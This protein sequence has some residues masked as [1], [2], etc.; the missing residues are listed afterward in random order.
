[1]GGLALWALPAAEVWRTGSYDALFRF[2][3]RQPKGPTN[4]LAIIFLEKDPDGS[5]RRQRVELTQLLN[6]L[7]DDGCRLVVLDILLRTTNANAGVDQDLARAIRRQRG[8]VLMAEQKRV[9]WQSSSQP[10]AVAGEP[11]LACEPFLTAAGKTNWGVAWFDPDPSD[12]V[13]RRHWP[14]E[15]RPSYPSLAEAAA[16]LAGAALVDDPE[17]RPN[18]WLRY[19]GPTGPWIGLSHQLALTNKPG[20]FADK[21]VFVGARPSTTFPGDEDDEFLTPYT[22]FTGETVGGVE[23]HAT[24]FLNLIN[25]EWLRRFSWWVEIAIIC[26]LDPGWERY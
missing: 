12:R 4:G 9:T 18:R 10:S 14:S 11:I 21:I 8:I 16:R 19:Y 13:T 25:D 3:T 20:F 22:R 17:D 7:A 5:V 15:E 23:L 26:C 2:G 1:V 24:A 6:K